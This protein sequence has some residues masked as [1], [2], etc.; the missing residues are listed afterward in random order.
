MKQ[1]YPEYEVIASAVKNIKSKEQ[2]NN[3]LLLYDKVVLPAYWHNVPAAL[4]SI[5]QKDKIVLFANSTCAYRCSSFTCYTYASVINAG[6][7][8]TFNCA[9]SNFGK[10][11]HFPVDKKL[12]V[13]F[14]EFKVI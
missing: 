4:K 1:N 11:T 14:D 2:I 13:G 12:Y 5:S 10:C 6:R 7:T 8:G 9:S 3:H